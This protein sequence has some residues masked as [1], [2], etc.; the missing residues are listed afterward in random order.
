MSALAPQCGF[1]CLYETPFL[2]ASGFE[3]KENF[4]EKSAAAALFGE[5]AILICSRNGEIYLFK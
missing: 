5:F 1:T 3:E 4:F 2:K